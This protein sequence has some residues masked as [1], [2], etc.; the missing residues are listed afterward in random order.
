MCSSDPLACGSQDIGE[1]FRVSEKILENPCILVDV[2]FS[3]MAY[4][5][6]F[7]TAENLSILDREDPSSVPLNYVNEFRLDQE[8]KKLTRKKGVF[9]YDAHDKLREMLC[10]NLT[11][12]GR[13]F[14]RLIIPA[15]HHP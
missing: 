11:Y 5:A 14:A 1:M 15:F 4:S 9:L 13:Y 6:N 12:R 2:N 7:F 3:Y 8:F 10:H